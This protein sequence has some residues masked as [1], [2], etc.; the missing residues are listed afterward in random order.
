MRKPAAW[1]RAGF[2]PQTKTFIPSDHT[3]RASRAITLFRVD[4]ILIRR[5]ETVA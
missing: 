3:W 4:T 5:K 2:V 1:Q